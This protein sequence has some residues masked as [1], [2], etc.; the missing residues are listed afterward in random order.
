MKV[1]EF[2]HRVRTDRCSVEPTERFRK[3]RRHTR[4]T[5][6]LAQPSVLSQ[7]EQGGLARGRKAR[8]LLRA[9]CL[10]YGTPGSCVE[11]GGGGSPE[12]GYNLSQMALV[13]WKT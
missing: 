13:G 3:H 2:P 7:D 12:G 9:R 4:S 8:G 6:G 11:R 10:S 5:E 1:S